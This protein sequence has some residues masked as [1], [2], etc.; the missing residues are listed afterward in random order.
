[1]RVRDVMSS[2][3]LV[4]VEPGASL[5]D[6]A[7]AMAEA[8]VGSVLVVSGGRLAGIFTERDLVRAV[9]SGASLGERVESF[10]TREPVTVKPDDPLPLAASKMV[11][12]GFRHLPV[13][14]EDGRPIGVVSVR[15]VLRALLAGGSWP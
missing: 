15:D 13:V 10:M 5:L 4:S 9:A 8:G 14:D 12:G 6:A 1:M 3:R 2:S 7:R 11:E